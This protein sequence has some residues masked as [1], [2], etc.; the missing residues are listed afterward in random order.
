MATAQEHA[1]LYGKLRAALLSRHFAF[2]R[3]FPANY[4]SLYNHLGS[5]HASVSAADANHDDAALP[6]CDGQ[7]TVTPSAYPDANG[8][9]ELTR[10]DPATALIERWRVADHERENPLMFSGQLLTCLAVEHRLGSTTALPILRQALFSIGS[11][12]KFPATPGFTGYPIRW[13][14][15]TCDHWVTELQGSQAHPLFCCDFQIDGE[16]RYRY[17]TSFD[18]PTYV[19]PT[20]VGAGHPA[21]NDPGWHDDLGDPRQPRAVERLTCLQRY[22]SWEV[23]QDELVGLMLGYDMV[24]Q[25]VSDAGVRD[26]VRRQVANL[27]DYLAEHGYLL[28]RPCG[29][30]NARGASGALPCFEFPFGNV[31]ERITGNRFGSRVGFETACEQAG[32]WPC[33]RGVWPWLVMG[34]VVTAPFSFVLVL[35]ARVV[36]F[37]FELIGVIPEAEAARVLGQIALAL[38]PTAGYH[39]VMALGVSGLRGCF[40]V[41]DEGARGEFAGAYLMKALWD[42]PIRYQVWVTAE[43]MYGS[44]SAGFLPFLGLTGLFDA[45]PFKRVANYY[46]DWYL[47]R[48]RLNPNDNPGAN[49]NAPFAMAAAMVLGEPGIEGP[50]RQ[51][52][53]QVHTAFTSVRAGELTLRDENGVREDI[54]TQPRLQTGP[55]DALEYMTCLALSWLHV[56]SGALA[57]ESGPIDYRPEVAGA[58][59]RPVVPGGVAAT[60]T[61]PGVTSTPFEGGDPPDVDVFPPGGGTSKPAVP[62]PELGTILRRDH[63]TVPIPESDLDVETNIQIGPRDAVM[64]TASGR[65]WAGVWLTGDNG[66]EGWLHWVTDDPYYP[67]HEGLNRHP[68]ALLYKLVD[69]A[70]IQEIDVGGVKLRLLP[71]RYYYLGAKASYVNMEGGPRMLVLRINDNKPGNGSGAFTCDIVVERVS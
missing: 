6:A 63:Y 36:G 35:V 57:T 22:R 28:V 5:L 24:Y 31:F 8:L 21:S 19:P 38:G 20:N 67:L 30:F 1:E 47:A 61:V 18:D 14:P 66:P 23:S 29:G 41:W 25:L 48:R 55:A 10:N 65:V 37:L 45:D 9:V 32:V 33:M 40:D 58:W 51:S 43:K 39:A 34:A 44:Y 59:P 15:T 54:V 50:L 17:C 13:D 42:P 70:R 49:A 12:F 46:R 27:G 68:F 64:M 26:E 3:Y 60:G 71:G 2:G 52:L 56:Q 62:E 16:R 7:T 69:P 53:D 4:L 11:M